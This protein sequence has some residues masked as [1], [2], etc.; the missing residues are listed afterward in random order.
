MTRAGYRGTTH[1]FRTSGPVMAI[2][3]LALWTA[4]TIFQRNQ[5]E[6]P[7][8]APRERHTT[9]ARIRS[10]DLAL[11]AHRFSCFRALI[12][13]MSIGPSENSPTSA[14]RVSPRI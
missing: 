5:D 8:V 2:F 12:R 7:S 3:P 11:Y 13:A 14:F 4:Q 10:A 9:S 6:F 1:S